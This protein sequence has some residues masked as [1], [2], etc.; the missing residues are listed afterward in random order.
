MFRKGN[1]LLGPSEMEGEYA[2]EDLRIEVGVQVY[3]F[4]LVRLK[5]SFSSLRQWLSDHRRDPSLTNLGWIWI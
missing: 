1:V 2:G 4:L 5:V 3:S